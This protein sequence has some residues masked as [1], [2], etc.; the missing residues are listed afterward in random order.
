[1][2]W[3]TI[4]SRIAALAAQALWGCQAMTELDERSDWARQVA[5]RLR[6]HLP[7]KVLST[8]FAISVFMN[9]YFILL[10]HPLFPVTLI[11]LT[12]IDGAIGFQPWSLVPYVSLWF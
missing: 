12:A 6:E 4:A 11:P 5:R 9:I 10:R 3:H 8:S 1:M 7:L 2:E